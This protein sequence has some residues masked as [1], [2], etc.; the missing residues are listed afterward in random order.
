MLALC[1]SAAETV[2][3]GLLIGP[4][5]LVRAL[6]GR[7]LYHLEAGAEFAK[8]PL[9]KLLTRDQRQLDRLTPVAR[10]KLMAQVRDERA[11]SRVRPEG[12]RRMLWNRRDPPRG[13]RRTAQPIPHCLSR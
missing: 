1:D 12:A 11:A 9:L 6:T 13:A 4:H 2:L 8:N 7:R 3:T 5:M 10:D